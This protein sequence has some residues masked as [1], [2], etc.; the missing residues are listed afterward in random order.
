MLKRGFTLTASLIVVILI[1]IALFPL[2]RALSTTLFVSADTEANIIALNLA[3]GKMEEI[4]N[5]SFAAVTNEA[6]SQIPRFPRFEREVA[7]TSPHA[8]L[9]DVKITVFWGVSG[10]GERAV[11]L[12]TY[13]TN[14]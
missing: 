13:A 8:N 10:G 6:R 7:V 1:V 12:E 2:L 9:K 3:M 4:R 5:A 11:T 14:Y